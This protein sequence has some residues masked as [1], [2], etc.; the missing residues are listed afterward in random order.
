MSPLI[1]LKQGFR[2]IVDEEYRFYFNRSHLGMYRNMPDEEYLKKLFRLKMGY[3][4]NLDD[5]KTFSEKIQWLKLYDRKPEYTKMVD[6]YEVKK[7][8]ADHIGGEYLIPTLGVWNHFNEIDFD[9]FPDQFVLKCTHDSHGLSICKDKTKWNKR[10]AKKKL[11]QGLHRNYYYGLREWPYKN[12][13]PRILA[14]KYME[15]AETKEL[16]DYKFFCFN[17]QVRAMFIATDRQDSSTD[18]KFD[19]FDMK[20][21]HLP[22][23]NG[24]P[25]AQ[26]CPQLPVNFN[27][28]QELA[29]VLSKDI[30]HVRVDFYEV[31]KKIYFGE[32]TFFHWSGLKPFDPP[33]WDRI[34]GEWIDLPNKTIE[35]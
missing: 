20:G 13:K 2:Y 34:F 18:T 31:N 24:H 9:K 14:E 33:E 22:F 35:R 1:M 21:N 4:L 19:F 15:D 5:P 27:R 26:P 10:E 23:T 7:Y 30:P 29:E 28:M 6:K 16:R 32:I 11:E 12:V 3:S 8:V 17:G 25:N